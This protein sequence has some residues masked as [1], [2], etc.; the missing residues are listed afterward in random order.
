LRTPAWIRV[1]ENRRFD[2][3]HDEASASCL[4]E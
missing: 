1:G 4:P 2:V 3:M